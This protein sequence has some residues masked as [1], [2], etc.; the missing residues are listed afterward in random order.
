MSDGWILGNTRLLNAVGGNR[1]M[2]D[3]ILNSQQKRIL[4]EVAS[5]GTIVYKELDANAN[6]IG[7]F[8]P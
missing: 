1:V 3:E 5:D 7:V 2:A 4:A 6:L 8:S